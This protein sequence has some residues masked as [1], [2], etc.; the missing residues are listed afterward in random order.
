[1]SQKIVDK[2]VARSFLLQKSWDSKELRC[3]GHGK[4]K[5]RNGW[6]SDS[7]A[8]KGDI[9]DFKIDKEDS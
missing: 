7:V 9:G 8:H 6:I 2:R 5:D 4:R 1:M 3:Q